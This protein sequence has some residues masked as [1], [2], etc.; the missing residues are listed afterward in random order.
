[1][2]PLHSGQ[3]PEPGILFIPFLPQLFLGSS[4]FFIGPGGFR[5]LTGHLRQLLCRGLLSIFQRRGLLLLVLQIAGFF[6]H[7]CLLLFQLLLQ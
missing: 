5:P 3:H 1:M 7:L 2:L 4:V 6:L